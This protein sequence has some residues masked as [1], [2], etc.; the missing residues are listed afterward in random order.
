MERLKRA[1]GHLK[2]I[3]AMLEHELA[4]AKDIRR[5]FGDGKASNRQIVLFGIT[6]GLIPCPVVITVLLPYLQLKQVAPGGTL[7]LASAS[8]WR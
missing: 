7:V 4:H 8:V 3:I 5:C 6:S 2:G 1:E